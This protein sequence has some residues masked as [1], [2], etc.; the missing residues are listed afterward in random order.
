MSPA[1]QRLQAGRLTTVFG[2]VLAGCSSPADA[3]PASPS[4]AAPSRTATVA[5]SAIH[6]A[7]PSASAG[8]SIEDL[9]EATIDI[10]G[11]PDLP[12]EGFGSMWFLAPDSDEP[13]LVR[14]D[15]RTNE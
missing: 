14:V 8:D 9:A 15:P 4:S 5:S 11:E 13:A 12:A 3:P 10:A 2:L 1:A 6:A 7:T